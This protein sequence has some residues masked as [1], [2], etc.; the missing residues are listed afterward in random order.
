MRSIAVSSQRDSVHTTGCPLNSKV[1]SSENIHYLGGTKHRSISNY[2]NCIMQS[3]MLKDQQHPKSYVWF[4]LRTG[5]Q[6]PWSSKAA[7]CMETW[8]NLKPVIS[9]LHLRDTSCIRGKQNGQTHKEHN[10]S[11]FFLLLFWIL[12]LL[13]ELLN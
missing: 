5:P 11:L 1:T 9:L 7:A 8:T 4:K 12:V 3:N 10:I 6:K 13:K 2:C